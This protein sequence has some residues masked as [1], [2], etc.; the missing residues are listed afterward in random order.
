MAMG[1]EAE[2]AISCVYREICSE[3]PPKTTKRD[4][5]N[6]MGGPKCDFCRTTLN[7][8][9]NKM[10]LVS[11]IVILLVPSVF[12]TK[13]WLSQLPSAVSSIVIGGNFSLNGKPTNLAHFDASSGKW[14]SGFDSEV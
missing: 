1:G 11:L 10:F 9:V 5:P 14:W 7:V 2:T 4:E 6:A 13:L 3:N 12:G 8:R